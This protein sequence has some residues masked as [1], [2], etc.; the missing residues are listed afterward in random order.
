MYGLHGTIVPM[1]REIDRYRRE[2]ICQRR[3]QLHSDDAH[4]RKEEERRSGN[5]VEF[6]HG[7]EWGEENEEGRKSMRVTSWS[8]R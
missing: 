3:D 8:N 6:R 7:M 2:R 4:F 1:R 5:R